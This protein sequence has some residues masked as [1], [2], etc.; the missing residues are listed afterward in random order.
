MTL[1]EPQAGSDLSGVTTRAER[2]GDERYRIAG[3]K[4]YITYGDQDM[5]DNIVHLVLARLSDAPAGTRGI[6]LFLVPKILVD[7][8]GRLESRNDVRCIGIER[9]PP[10]GRDRVLFDLVFRLAHV[11][12]DRLAPYVLDVSCTA[13]R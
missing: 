5:T 6:S 2:I 10:L 7:S 1:T 13:S 3:Q 4:I 12:S 8:D 11:F 9:K